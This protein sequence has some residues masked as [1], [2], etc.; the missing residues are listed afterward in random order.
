MAVT[1]HGTGAL[2]PTGTPGAT[3][4]PAL[5][6][7]TA[8]NDVGYLS[9]M[10]NAANT[11][12]AIA[13]WTKMGTLINSANQSTDWYW[14]RFTGSGDAPAAFTIAGGTALSTTNGLY[15]RVY[16]YRGAI[17]TG[18]PHEAVVMGGTPT[19][20]TGPLGSQVDTLG[21]DRLVVRIVAVD[22][23]NTWASGHP[24]VGYTNNGPIAVS[25]VGGDCMMDAV[26]IPRAV[27]GAQAAAT[28]GTMTA[29]DFWRTLSFAIIP[30]P[31]AAGAGVPPRRQPHRG[32]IMRS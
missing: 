19:S 18:T 26:S 3:I 9:V 32:L 12:P 11:F 17:T 15:G 1:W 31:S 6:A 2:A 13:G 22:D 7:S 8:A 29:A 4:S 28:I 23:D 25:T 27:A 16:V 20:S 30:A 14:R 24:P 10:T 21:A 5:P